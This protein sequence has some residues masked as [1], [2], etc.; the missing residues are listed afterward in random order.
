MPDRAARLM[1]VTK[2]AFVYAENVQV[3]KELP[4]SAEGEGND[5]CTPR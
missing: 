3:F 4:V 5:H 2:S 1:F